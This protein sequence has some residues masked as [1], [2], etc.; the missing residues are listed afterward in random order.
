V[1]LLSDSSEGRRLELR[2]LFKQFL[3]EAAPRG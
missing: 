1:P 3:D 2:G